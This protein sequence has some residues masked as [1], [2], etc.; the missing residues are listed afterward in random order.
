MYNKLTIRLLDLDTCMNPC[1]SPCGRCRLC[2]SVL[3]KCSSSNVNRSK[4]LATL[5]ASF[6]TLCNV[7]DVMCH[8]NEADPWVTPRKNAIGPCTRPL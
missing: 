5:D 1:A 3:R 2:S 6:V 7:P 8:I 4:F